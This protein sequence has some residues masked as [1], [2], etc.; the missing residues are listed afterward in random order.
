MEDVRIR[1]DD[2]GP[3]G[4]RQELDAER[5]VQNAARDIHCPDVSNALALIA[6]NTPVWIMK[7]QHLQDA[8]F[9]RFERA[10]FRDDLIDPSRL[11]EGEA[12]H[13]EGV[14]ASHEHRIDHNVHARM[15]RTRDVLTRIVL[16]ETPLAAVETQVDD[17]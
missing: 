13:R 10:V 12:E 15:R 9:L 17:R 7:E 8:P 3:G 14:V 11:V 16:H 2:D 1:R 4:V 5:I 6:M